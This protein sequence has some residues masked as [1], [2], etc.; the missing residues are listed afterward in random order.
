MKIINDSELHNNTE[1][2]KARKMSS[3][4]IKLRIKDK[5]KG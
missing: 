2:F 4:G 5:S 1:C 3:F